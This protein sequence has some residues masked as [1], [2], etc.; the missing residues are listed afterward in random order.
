MSCAPWRP[1]FDEA[2]IPRTKR[3]ERAREDATLKSEARV[4]QPIVAVWETSA[5]DVEWH[6]RQA[7]VRQS[8]VGYREA[9]LPPARHSLA[10]GL[11]AARSEQTHRLFP[12]NP[13][14]R[15]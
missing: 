2:P 10:L 6:A 1:A 7:L 3:Q 11:R 8:P 9:R 5:S 13:F 14:F 15:R 12:I 4:T